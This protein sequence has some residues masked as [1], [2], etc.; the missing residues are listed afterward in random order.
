MGIPLWVGRS[1]RLCAG[2]F[3]LCTLYGIDEL[4]A[5]VLQNIS[6]LTNQIVSL[7]AE[8]LKY[9][10]LATGSLVILTL[11]LVGLKLKRTKTARV[12][13][14]AKLVETEAVDASA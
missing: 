8:T 13:K 11:I 2:F 14:S 10:M 12:A 6:K 3:I 4:A 1:L 7:P 5:E 9:I